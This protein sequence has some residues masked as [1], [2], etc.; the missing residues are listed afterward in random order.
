MH[1]VRA[2]VVAAVAAGKSLRSVA[3]RFDVS[4]VTAMRWHREACP[5]DPEAVAAAMACLAEGWTARDVAQAAGVT[6]GTVRRWQR[7][8]RR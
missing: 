5:D 6:L 4:Q 7:E 8:A 2:Q 3:R 1:E